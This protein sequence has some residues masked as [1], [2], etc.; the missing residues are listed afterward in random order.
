MSLQE[1]LEDFNQVL[2]DADQVN[3]PVSETYMRRLMTKVE[4]LI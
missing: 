2:F 1:A 4:D 3:I